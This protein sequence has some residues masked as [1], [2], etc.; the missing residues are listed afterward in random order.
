MP[1]IRAERKAAEKKA[2]EYKAIEYKEMINKYENVKNLRGAITPNILRVVTGVF[3]AN[4]FLDGL[5]QS[6]QFS[7]ESINWMQSAVS[8][9]TLLGGI[10]CYIGVK[11]PRLRHLHLNQ[12]TEKL[13]ALGPDMGLTTEAVLNSS[14]SEIYPHLENLEE[15]LSTKIKNNLL[16]I[17]FLETSVQLNTSGLKILGIYKPK[18]KQIQSQYPEALIHTLEY[19]GA[20]YIAYEFKKNLKPKR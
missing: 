18:D 10:T 2:I 17:R 16:A 5:R 15:R 12:Y 1:K 6:E 14:L 3:V 7:S 8:I 9:L 19:L 11:F 20:D 13:V 4:S